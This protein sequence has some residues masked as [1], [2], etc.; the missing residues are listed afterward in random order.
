MSAPL[1]Q[2]TGLVRRFDNGTVA[3][4]HVNVTIAAG[5]RV[6]LVGESGSGKSTLGRLL[7][8]LDDANAGTVAFDG[9]DLTRQ[10]GKSLLWFRRRAQ[11][12]FQDPSTALNP[13]LSVGE[14]VAE[15]LII[16]GLH[17]QDRPAR[18]SALLA[19]VG[20]DVSVLHRRPHELSGG[21]KQRV[22]IA[23]ALAVEPGFLLLDEPVSALDVS[24][25]AQ[26]VN[27]LA[28]LSERRG[29]TILFVAHDLH[30]VR[31]LCERV[32]VMYRGHIVEEGPTEALFET[33]QHPYT[34]ALLAAVPVTDPSLRRR[35]LPLRTV[36]IEE[37]S[38][39]GCQFR[40]R[41]P[42]AR[43]V[44]AATV[45]TLVAIGGAGVAV[46]C[47]ARHDS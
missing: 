20:L 39:G 34:R 45:P 40:L 42:E 9:H 19:D 14:L 43:P 28:D 25:Q 32:L 22:G 15:G 29:L 44:C 30:V 27:L 35:E 8:R 11:V 37:L 3:V 13:R 24:V 18:V 12:V 33:P 46:A 38:E 10:Y 2:A 23:R 5:E 6:G 17:S 7:L 16:H 36:A 26:I 21:Q 1:V 47:H 31:H 41:C 4:D